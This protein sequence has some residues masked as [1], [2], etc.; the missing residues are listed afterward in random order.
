MFLTFGRLL[1][2]MLLSDRGW[3]AKFRDAYLE[4]AMSRQVSWFTKAHKHPE[5]LILETDAVAIYRL[6]TTF[7]VIHTICHSSTF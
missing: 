7:E 5:L 2:Y 6:K 4:E 1:V 3:D